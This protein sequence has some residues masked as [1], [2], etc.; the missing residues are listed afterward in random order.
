MGRMTLDEID[1]TDVTLFADGPPHHLFAQMRAESPARWNQ[2]TDGEGFWSVTRE[3]DVAAVSR[4]FET[5][6]SHAAGI[7][8]NPDKAIPLDM[9]RNLLLYKD[10]PEHTKYRLILQKAF[11]PHTV[12]ALEG[13]IR[14]VVTRI[15]D[16]VIEA[17]SCDFVGDIAVPVPLS[18]LAEL[19]GLP[20]E[21]RPTL[22]RW[23]DEI[24]AGLQSSESAAAMPTFGEMG[25]YLMEQI[26]IQGRAE[27]ES[28]VRTL[29]AAE[30]DGERLTDV[31]ILVFFGLLVFAGND[32]TRNTASNGMLTL[33][34]HPEQWRLIC[35]Q[36]EL[37]P[38]AVEEILRW[39]SV[40]NYFVRTATRDT[41]L[42]GQRIEAG[43]KVVIW[44]TSASRDA[45]AVADPERFD[46]TRAEV[47]HTAFGGGGR[48]FCLGAGLARLE[49][50]VLFEELARRMPD[51]T[52]AGSV[53]R[54]SSSWAN[55]LTSMPVTFTPGSPEEALAA[56]AN[57]HR[58]R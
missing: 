40:V 53:E 42:G 9:A 56:A 2:T 6:S 11:V 7:F 22:K 18:V 17:G 54:L 3:A 1:L 30:V 20:Q 8:L 43:Q 38:R 4:D 26:E 23:T 25:T 51:M 15:V 21:D 39:T 5:F 10:P 41:E 57:E 58:R 37:I 19:L 27:H 16:A 31:E 44:Y 52:V 33:L 12:R 32:T 48:H 45:E 55:S 35:E 24:E 50:R 47:N 46:I 29:R 13:D 14:A 34:E 49:L 28:L 36:P